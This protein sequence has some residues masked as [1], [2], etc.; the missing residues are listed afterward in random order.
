[1]QQTTERRETVRILILTAALNGG[2]T[3]AAEALA[4]QLKKLNI[5]WEILDALTFFAEKDARARIP[6]RYAKACLKA[7]RKQERLL[8]ELAVKGVARLQEK[9][10]AEPFE[11]IL[12]THVF[13]SM[14]VAHAKAK[15]SFVT[16]HYFVATDYVC[17][18]GMTEI[19]LDGCF[20]AHGMLYGDFVRSAIT[21]EK[22][23]ASGIP[24]PVRFYETVE[25]KAARAELELP[26]DGSVLLLNCTG[27]SDR[28]TQK[29]VEI[30]LGAL[31]N[32]CHT[33]VLCGN[34]EALANALSEKEGARLTVVRETRWMHLYLSASDVYLTPPVGLSVAQGMAK[35]VP[36]VLI[37]G[38]LRGYERSNS[39]F[40]LAQGVADLSTTPRRAAE[41]AI[42]L[43]NSPETVAA[44][45]DV[46][47]SIMPPVAADQICR[48]ILRH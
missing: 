16:P 47:E 48:F 10:L 45:K 29:R 27:Q 35:R 25:Q 32:D 4:E 21:A 43:L 30:L 34:N 3:T 33:V 2:S 9:L 36:T 26:L 15:F 46:M 13:A 24:L 20:L 19:T 12:S 8:S 11:V 39:A 23:L 31:P 42:A 5:E 22:L 44:R 1:M 37:C 18:P 7:D 17:P 6:A 14:V 28:R 41:A 38:A 40:L